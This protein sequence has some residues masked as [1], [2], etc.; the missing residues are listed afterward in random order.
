[1]ILAVGYCIC[2]C[3][4]LTLF[5][6]LI[7][8]ASCRDAHEEGDFAGSFLLCAETCRLLESLQKLSATGELFASVN[9]LYA[10]I[11]S[12]LEATLSSTCAEFEEVQYCKVS[13]PPLP[14]ILYLQSP[15]L[16]LCDGYPVPA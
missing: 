4:V 10:D 1:M 16:P 2:S 6:S 3:R 11:V 13:C 9:R 12:R 8:I 5:H 15:S 14:A 7:S